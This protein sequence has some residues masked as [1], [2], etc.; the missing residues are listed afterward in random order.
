MSEPQEIKYKLKSASPYEFHE[1]KR[2]LVFE[3]QIAVEQ[4]AIIREQLA[5]CARKENVNQFRNCREL[6]EKYL[7]LQRDRYH[8]MLFPEDLQPHNREIPGI[9]VPK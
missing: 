4:M 3:Y 7:Q 6:R 9:I 5:D 2:Q 1:R 8:G